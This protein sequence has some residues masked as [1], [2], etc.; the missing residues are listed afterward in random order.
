[1]KNQ[2]NIIKNYKSPEEILQ[3]ELLE[4]F[5]KFEKAKQKEQKLKTI[6]F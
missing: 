3:A 6:K 1:M 2:K 4:A 5:A